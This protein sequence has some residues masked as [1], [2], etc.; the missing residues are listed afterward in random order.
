MG[1]SNWLLLF[2]LVKG[3]KGVFRSKVYYRFCDAVYVI[4]YLVKE[5]LFIL[6]SLFIGFRV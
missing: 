3:G 2:F 4:R 6:Y 1:V 5:I